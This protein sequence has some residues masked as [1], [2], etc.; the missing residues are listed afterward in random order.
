[1]KNETEENEFYREEGSVW[2]PTTSGRAWQATTSGRAWQANTTGR[3]WQATTSGRTWQITTSPLSHCPLSTCHVTPRV[4]F[5][6]NAS[7]R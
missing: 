7:L 5:L 4:V 2:L 1:M 3:A 6:W